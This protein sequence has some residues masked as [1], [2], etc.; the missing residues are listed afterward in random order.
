MLPSGFM[1]FM[2]FLTTISIMLLLIGCASSGPSDE[3]LNGTWRSNSEATVAEIFRSDPRWADAPQEKRNAFR[4][5]FG[6]LTS[7]YSNGTVTMSLHGETLKMG[8]TVEERGKDFMV[9]KV[10]GT[11]DEN[12][13]VHIRFDSENQG[14]WVKTQTITGEEIE[15]RFD[16][17]I[18]P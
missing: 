4:N 17:I 7:T 13:T 12:R 16:K 6:H 18:S 14:Y 2:R 11:K 9:I 8:Y 15:E 10:G 3:R 5:L 1:Q